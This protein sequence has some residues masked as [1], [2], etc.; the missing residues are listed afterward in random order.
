MSKAGPKAVKVCN[1]VIIG[2]EPC[3]SGIVVTM[4]ARKPLGSGLDY[5]S[6]HAL[7]HCHNNALQVGLNPLNITSCTDLITTNCISSMALKHTF[8]CVLYNSGLYLNSLGPSDVILVNVGPGYSLL[9]DG[10]Q[11]YLQPMLIK[12]LGN[13]PA[14]V[15]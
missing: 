5:R 3:L 8:L 12:N 1:H 13:P 11:S 14:P 10:T 6:A 9:P 15:S 4:H 2:I 7:V